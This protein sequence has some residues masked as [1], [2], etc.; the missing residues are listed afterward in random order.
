VVPTS[1]MFTAASALTAVGVVLVLANWYAKPEA[2]MA[3]TAALAVF[4][5][6]AVVLRVSRRA[7]RRSPG[8]APAARGL[9]SVTTAVVF[10]A[11]MMGIP[12]AL[13]LARSYGL[14]D[15]TDV[16]RRSTGVL[17][18]AF[19][20]MLGNVMPKHLPPLSSMRCDGARRQ[21][22]H[23][24]AGWTWVLCGL[25]SAIGWLTLSIDAAETATMVLVVTA[26]AVTIAQILR[27]RRPRKDEP[28]HGLN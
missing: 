11:L 5:V 18:G 3:W 12:L 16:A 17:T 13:T 8:E 20:A 10:A 15:G 9:D 22:F 7:V 2:A 6:M 25:A 21:A 27:L 1:M 19:L 23:R 26:M 4:V 14:A 24:R 28:A